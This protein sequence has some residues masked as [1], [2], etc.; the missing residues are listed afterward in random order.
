MKNATYIESLSELEHYEHIS[1]TGGEPMLYPEFTEKVVDALNAQDAMNRKIYLYTA[2]WDGMLNKLAKYGKVDGI[3]YT[4][5]ASTEYMEDEGRR[6]SASDQTGYRM[7]QKVAV[8]NKVS[9]KN[10][11]SFRSYI[12]PNIDDSVAINPQAWDRLEIKPWIESGDCELPED[13][14]FILKNGVDTII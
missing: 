3:H 4:L 13:K 9:Y 11:I 6:L 14:L 2:K 12:D 1:L 5:H 7:I 8:L 10:D